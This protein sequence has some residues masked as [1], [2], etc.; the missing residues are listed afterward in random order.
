MTHKTRL[1]VKR[2]F[3]LKIDIYSSDFIFFKISLKYKNFCL[4][5]MIFWN[6]PPHFNTAFVGKS[7]STYVVSN[8]VPSL[9]T[10]YD[11]T[12]GNDLFL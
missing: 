9:G 12:S 5:K 7:V 11:V 1:Q 2:K 3:L 6:N 4:A 10:S 8:K